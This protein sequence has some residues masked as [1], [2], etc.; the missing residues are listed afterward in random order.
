MKIAIYVTI[1]Q[2]QKTVNMFQIFTGAAFHHWFFRYYI[3]IWLIKIYNPLGNQPQS[4]TP[5][6][7]SRH[8][9]NYIV[10]KWHQSP[11]LFVA[12]SEILN[13]PSDKK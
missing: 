5:E 8:K 2:A 11:I 13:Y 7:P 1:S 3:M 6:T 10:H 9:I 4:Q 12:I